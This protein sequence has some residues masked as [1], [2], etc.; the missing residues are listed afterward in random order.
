M[1]DLVLASVCVCVLVCVG[2]SSAHYEH[3][4]FQRSQPASHREVPFQR[5][6]D[7]C[8]LLNQLVGLEFMDSANADLTTADHSLLQ[9]MQSHIMALALSEQKTFGAGN[10]IAQGVLSYHQPCC[11]RHLPIAGLPPDAIGS[12]HRLWTAVQNRF[13]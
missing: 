11:E 3:F 6:Q 13:A 8:P 12:M 4:H 9:H 2:V 5:H 1:L 10:V 7:T